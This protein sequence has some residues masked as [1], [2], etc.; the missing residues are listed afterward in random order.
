[1]QFGLSALLAA[2]TAAATVTAQISS[3]YILTAVPDKNGPVIN[4]FWSTV[5]FYNGSLWTG[6]AKTDYSSEPFI[7]KLSLHPTPDSKYL[8]LPLL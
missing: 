3:G 6:D 1:M 4:S 8:P 2:V 7:C 5:S